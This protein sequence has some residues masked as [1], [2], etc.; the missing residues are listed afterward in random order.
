MNCRHS[1]IA[2]FKSVCFYYF[3]SDTTVIITDVGIGAFNRLL[4]MSA[5]EELSTGG[6]Q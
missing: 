1:N 4:F 2:L 5:V 3:G 6:A